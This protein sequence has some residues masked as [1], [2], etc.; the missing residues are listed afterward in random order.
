MNP[1]RSIAA[2]IAGLALTTAAWAYPDRPI[3][4]VAPFPPGSV[5]DVLARAIAPKLAEAW[6]QTVVV[7]NRSGAGGNVG[8]EIVA[9][10]PPDGYTLLMGT[11]GTN[12]INMSVYPRMP[13]DTLKDFAPITFVA[14]SYLLLCLHP[15]VP[16]ANVK[17][18]I[19][20]ARARPGQLTFGSGGGGTTPHLAGEMFK[21]LAGVDMVHVAYKGSPQATI[22]LLAGR[23]SLSFA[24]ASAVL[25]QVR[26]GK[27]RV[28]GISSAR[29]DAAL[30]DVPTIAEAGVPGFDATP[31]F[32]LFAPA[33]TPADVVNKLNA[34]VVRIL[35][36]ADVRSHYANLGLTAA[37]ST[38]AELDTW[39]RNEVTRWAKVVKASGARID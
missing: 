19:A 11:N 30:P 28:I 25:P 26:A 5:T 10:S 16:A 29:R 12:A 24:N 3:R 9:K 17:A 33:G 35:G 2:G 7:D 18:L 14:T 22:D 1:T 4:L 15:S 39:V 13:Y 27:L 38:P 37:T 8:A 21:A 6:S 20:L 31:W 32:A 23:L 34:E 36:L